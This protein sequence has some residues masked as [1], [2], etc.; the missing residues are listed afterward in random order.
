MS[1][2]VDKAYINLLA[3]YKQLFLFVRELSEITVT[4]EANFALCSWVIESRAL[5]KE[6][7]KDD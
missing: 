4:R 3:D 2:I 1:D 5:L 6:V 7:N